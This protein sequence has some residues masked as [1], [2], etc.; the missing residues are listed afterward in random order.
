MSANRYSLKWLSLV[1]AIMVSPP[2]A[3]ERLQMAVASNFQPTMAKLVRVF[4]S[5]SGHEV[6]VSYGSTGKHY[7]QILNGAP[8]DLFLAADAERPRKLEMDDLAVPGT[9]F[10]YAIGRL[11]LWSPRRAL[12][13][14]GQAILEAGA[15]RFLAIANPRTAPYG[16]AA[17]QALSHLGL[18]ETLQSRIARGENVGQ[19]MSYVLSGNAELGL[20]ALS[21]VAGA[22]DAEAAVWQ[23]PQDLY[24]PIE[25]QA[26]LLVESEAGRE[27]LAF[28]GGG[29]AAA[30]I[31]S[32]GYAL[33]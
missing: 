24:D 3:A 18:W 32:S 23:V 28:L 4:E 6:A 15:F 13:E 5:Q 22:P 25:Q 30:I 7:A 27:F 1:V 9:R 29:Q 11:V 17:E 31:L 2:A 21:Q 16:V 20:V 12:D 8:F 10:T 19:A 26:V 33:P 14:N